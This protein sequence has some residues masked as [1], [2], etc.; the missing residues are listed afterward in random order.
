MQ[1]A[2]VDFDCVLPMLRSGPRNRPQ[3]PPSDRGSPPKPP[4][5]RIKAL[6]HV[7]SV[8]FRTSMEAR[9]VESLSE[10]NA[11]SASTGV[12]ADLMSPEGA[13]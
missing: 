6:T 11:T 1:I 9:G 3:Y 2:A 12:V 5:I 8:P 13:P 7:R 10:D 4:S